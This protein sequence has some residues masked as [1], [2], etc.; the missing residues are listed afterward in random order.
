MHSARS[1]E[2]T[3]L[4]SIRFVKYSKSTSFGEEC[5]MT[6][7]FTNMMTNVGS[8]RDLLLTSVSKIKDEIKVLEM[9]IQKR[10]PLYIYHLR[11][12]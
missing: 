1:R 7:R 6:R 9:L 10:V 12:G 11:L 4:H 8:T 2:L 5:L 3:S